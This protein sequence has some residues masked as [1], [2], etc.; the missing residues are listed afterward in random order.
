MSKAQLANVFGRNPAEESLGYTEIGGVE[1]EFKGKLTRSVV[2][3]ISKLKKEP[4]WMRKWRLRNLELFYKLPSPKWLIG[5]EELDLEEISHYVKPETEK[6]VSWDDLPKE[7]REAYEKLGIK[8]AEA[9]V[10]GGLNAQ[11]DSEVILTRVKEYVEKKGVIVTDLDTAVQKYPDLVKKYFMRIFPPEH[12]FA[13]LHG[14]LWSGGTFI[15]VPPGVK[16]ETPIESFFLIGRA[17]EGNFEHSLIIADRN[18]YVHWIE[19]CAAPILKKYSFHDGMVEAYVAEGARLHITTLQNWSSQ[20][21]NIN[22]K[23]AIVERNGYV[24]WIEGSIGSKLSYVYPS[25]VLKGENASMESYVITFARDGHIKDGGSKAYHLAPNTK[26][27]IVSKSISMT[28]GLN[29]Y[30]GLVRIVKGAKNAKSYTSCDSLLIDEKSKTYT[31]PHI[32][33]DEPTAIIGHEASVGKLSDLLMFYLRSRGLK[34]NE[35]VSMI[36][37]GF[38]SDVLARLPFEQAAIIKSALDLEFSKYGVVG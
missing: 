9:K 33:N 31:F 24:E 5:L 16:V 12:K 32:Q 17:A 28:G 26:S 25:A 8:E 23:R 13:A 29:V 22:N 35:A 19:G 18:S 37:G 2:E 10:L 15:Y 20:V 34:E 3:E 11:L 38:L 27:R 4:E 30:R 21:I 1:I 14:A 6:A 7:I 36:V